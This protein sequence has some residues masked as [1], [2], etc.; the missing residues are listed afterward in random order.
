MLLRLF[1]CFFKIGLFGFGGGMGVVAL[2]Q[3]DVVEKNKWITDTQFTDIVA[4]SQMTPGPIGIN[5]ATYVGYTAM[6]NNGQCRSKAVISS[7]VTSGALVLPSFILMIV[8]SIFFM[9]YKD[10]PAVKRVLE[11][12]RLTVSGLFIATILLLC[13]AQTF[14]ELHTADGGF[15]PQVAISIAIAV[16]SLYA[17][18]VKKISP[19][20]VV[21]CAG[22]VGW[23]CYGWLGI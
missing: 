8:V 6:A 13:N 9:R 15:N 16:V 7:L 11:L 1:W 22:T 21:A 18:Y 20:A 12:I 3:H 2:I 5:A 17:G 19:I 10:N 23:I 4:I 14:G